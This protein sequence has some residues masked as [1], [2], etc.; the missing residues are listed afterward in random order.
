M[1]HPK[2]RLTKQGIESHAPDVTARAAVGSDG[3]DSTQSHLTDQQRREAVEFGVQAHRRLGKGAEWSEVE[4]TLR[5]HW[6]HSQRSH[7]FSWARAINA[8]REGWQRED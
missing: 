1:A 2:G 5:N 7:R 8:A 3:G 4:A 6:S